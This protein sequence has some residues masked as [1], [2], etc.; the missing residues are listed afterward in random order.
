M[1]VFWRMSIWNWGFMN[2]HMAFSATLGMSPSTAENSPRD[3]SISRNRVY[4][5]DLPQ[6]ASHHQDHH[7]LCRESHP[8]P[9]VCNYYWVWVDSIYIY[10]VPFWSPFGG[11]SIYFLEYTPC[12]LELF[13]N[14]QTLWHYPQFLQI[15][16]NSSG[17]QNTSESKAD[18][19]KL[20]KTRPFHY[21]GWMLP[22]NL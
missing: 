20:L 17:W 2:L 8:E 11:P 13:S 1:F 16:P 10:T 9:L 5:L 4:T 21:F 12:H 7:I 19:C 18:H 3:M 22:A 14:K 6:D 15:S